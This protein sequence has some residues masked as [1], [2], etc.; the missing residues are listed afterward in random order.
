M[1][2]Q[3]ETK[4]TALISAWKVLDFYGFYLK[5]SSNKEAYISYWENFMLD[6]SCWKEKEVRESK[7]ANLNEDELIDEVY[8]VIIDNLWLKL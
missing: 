2:F 4:R 6:I 7:Y 5:F 3:T 1:Y 8:K